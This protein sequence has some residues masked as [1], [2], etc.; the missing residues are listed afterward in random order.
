MIVFSNAY[1]ISVLWIIKH[2]YV[3]NNT[4][5]IVHIQWKSTQCKKIINCRY[6]A[7]QVFL[8]KQKQMI[9]KVSAD[10]R[11][12]SALSI[13]MDNALWK[14]FISPKKNEFSLLCRI[15]VSVRGYLQTICNL[16]Y[17]V[18]LQWFNVSPSSGWP[19]CLNGHFPFAIS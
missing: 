11:R 1:N 16:K 13:Q 8:G 9:F 15:G 6:N 4:H 19:E 5:R 7:E 12:W 17:N 2:F 14:C 10:K 18:S 3:N